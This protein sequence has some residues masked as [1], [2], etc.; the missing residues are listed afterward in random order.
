HRRRMPSSG[1]QDRLGSRRRS[2]AS[3]QVGQHRARLVQDWLAG[4]QAQIEVFYLPAYS[5]ELNPDEGL[6]GSLK[7]AVPRMA[8]ARSR[9]ELKRNVIS[10]MRKLAKLPARVRSFFQHPTFRYAA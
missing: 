4:R 7:Q 9:E 1:G 6:N 8:P 10:H 5:P 2:H 3:L